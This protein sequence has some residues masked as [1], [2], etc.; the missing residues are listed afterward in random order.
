MPEMDPIDLLAHA[1]EN[2]K[3]YNW[4]AAVE[5][6]EKVL[7]QSLQQGD[8]VGAADIVERIG[9]C[10][11]RAAM[12]AAD[13]DEFRERMHLAVAS[14][15]KARD[16]FERANETGKTP[17]ILRSSA[18]IAYLGFWLSPNVS[19]KKR[20]L[21]DCWKLTKRALAAFKETGAALEFGNTYNSLSQSAFFSYNLE[22]EFRVRENLTRE[23]MDY[24][25]EAITL[26]SGIGET[27]ELARAYAETGI[28][29][30]S[31]GRIFIPDMVE[32]ERYRQRGLDYWRK[33]IELSEEAA[34]LELPSISGVGFDE[35]NWTMDELL[36]N[37][38]KA[39]DYCEKTGDKRL[40]GTSLEAMAFASTWKGMGTGDPDRRS[41]LFQTSLRYLEDAKK[42][43]SSIS[44]SSPR[45]IAC[46][47]M[48]PQAEYDWIAA[49]WE[50]DINKR[51]DLLKS[52]AMH[53]T[54]A[55]KIAKST[56]Y[57]GVIYTVHFTLSK[58]LG[59]LAQIEAN[60]EEK[61]R[62]LEK[63]LKHRK[64]AFSLVRHI[65]PFG[66]WGQG[67]NW[68]FLADLKVELSNLEKAPA[69]RKRMLE[70]AVLDQER[71]LQLQAKEVTWVKTNELSIFSAIGRAQYSHGESLARLYEAT[72]KK[73]HLT[74][75][76]RAF[77]EAAKAYKRSGLAGLV[78]GCSWKAA[79]IYDVLAEYLKSAKSFESASENYILAS[80]EMPQFASF[81]SEHASYMKAWA[82]IEKSRDEHEKE[83]YSKSREYYRSCSRHLEI[84]KKWSYL[85]SY[86]LAWS[87]LEHG[88]A[89]SRL[90]KPQ[91]A[92]IAFN[93]AGQAF[94]DSANSLPK[95]VEQLETSEE[96]DET[97]RLAKIAIL[98]R[99]YCIGRVL[100]E[101]AVISNMK[102][103]RVSS[104]K[105]YSSA[106][107]AFKEIAPDFNRKEARQDLQYAVTICGACEKVELAEERRDATLYEKAAKLFTKAS[108]ISRGKTAEL[109]AKGNSCFCQALEMGTKFMATSDLNFY[110]AA[111]LRL[112]NAA[113]YF[114]RVGLNKPTSYVEAMKKR[115]DAHVYTGRAEAE[116]EPE[117]RAKYYLMAEKCLKFSAELFAEARYLDKKNEALE[118]LGRVRKERQFVSSL[119]EVLTPPTSLSST[120]VVSMPNFAEKSAGLDGFE[121][122]NIKAIVSAPKEFVPNKEF[123]IKFDLA[124][125]GKATGLLVRIEDLMP[126]MCKVLSVPPCC[127]LED[128]SLNM[129]GKRLE[130]FSVES[131]SIWVQTADIGGIT[132][133]PKVVYIDELGNFRTCCVE[134]VQTFPIIEFASKAEQSIFNY[135]VDAFVEDCVKSRLGVNKA[136]WR[137]LPQIIKGAA[138]SK[139]SL[140]G[141]S[142]MLGHGL[143]GFERN[144]LVSIETFAGERGRGGH[145]LRV[146]IRHEKESVKR[147][148]RQKAP[149]LST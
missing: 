126:P 36:T 117:K 137:S 27:Y 97:L 136:G 124:N 100:M 83:N 130:P 16:L 106:A 66:Y 120:T 73:E 26:L 98:R 43:F 78:A 99:Q 111:K 149:N 114:Q 37:Y 113:G 55:V 68:K 84:T 129:R 94:R 12:Q 48:A 71:G 54:D 132:F 15:E 135:L 42:R 25:E 65:L 29:S 13:V 61:R 56:G 143:S 118:N 6:R 1:R 144:G 47:T 39:L 34:L 50:T 89:L 119:S 52:A 116:S 127:A 57:P 104:A 70:Q 95:K 86:Y 88:E 72:T 51:R 82:N 93:E 145:I 21:S 115:L 58:A 59:S 91:E 9:Y 142:G 46:W 122:V 133:S 60:K 80:K 28:W 128:A 107:R 44:F 121:S 10:F 146:R 3:R 49:F 147:Y 138:V 92:I 2:E 76:L 101:E 81:Y 18:M 31:F 102:G 19:R 103:D 148:V 7:S 64:K 35:I 85:S 14:Y 108:E 134:E 112:E 141:A 41:E 79:Q 63:A 131:V 123:E 4:I 90:D 33:A 53:G 5:Y 38:S 87:L 96:K 22:W 45:C 62:I 40:I 110:S 24:G 140:Y 32:R 139:R 23:A 67:A 75:A 30:S 11:Y 74:K 109:T 105:K 8:L 17:R 69:K 20:L 125:V 77:E